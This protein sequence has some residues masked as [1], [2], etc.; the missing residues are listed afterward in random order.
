MSKNANPIENEQDQKEDFKPAGNTEEVLVRTRYGR[1]VKPNR[2]PDF[3]Y[4]NVILELS[5]PTTSVVPKF[6]VAAR[7]DFLEVSSVGL[8]CCFFCDPANSQ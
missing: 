8:S 3:D 6:S 2:H 1:E 5:S 4:T 7:S